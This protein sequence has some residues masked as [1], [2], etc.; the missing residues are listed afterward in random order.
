MVALARFY[1][2]PQ[3]LV[4]PVLL[5]SKVKEMEDDWGEV[6]VVDFACL[7]VMS[8]IQVC[9]GFSVTSSPTP[10]TVQ[11]VWGTH[12][13]IVCCYVGSGLGFRDTPFSESVL[14]QRL[15]LLAC[16]F[17]GRVSTL[18]DPTQNMSRLVQN[19]GELEHPQR[20]PACLLLQETS[21]WASLGVPGC[22]WAVA[23][24]GTFS[25]KGHRVQVSFS[26]TEA[27]SFTEDILVK[28]L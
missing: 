21:L 27:F 8:P 24:T 2:A 9:G 28:L 15:R 10:E 20:L 22:P 6:V 17:A 7:T 5:K 18:G 25:G 12:G 19:L 16:H 23:P 13:E 3:V 4:L 11:H 14:L 1:E 26:F